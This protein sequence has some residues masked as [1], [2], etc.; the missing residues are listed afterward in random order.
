MKM[1]SRKMAGFG[2]RIEYWLI[3]Q[4]LKEGQDVYMPLVDYKGTDLLV[5]KSNGTF[6]EIQVKSSSKT[7][8]TGY[9]GLFGS[10]PHKDKKNYFYIFY[11]EKLN[12]IWIMSS[13]EF[14]KHSKQNKTGKHIGYRTIK[15]TGK[16]KD[17]SF[18]ASAKKGKKTNKREEYVHERFKKYITTDFSKFK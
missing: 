17:V 1:K 7:I 3:G 5:K 9:S 6:I 14:L 11:S 4:I 18:E 12:I 13:A 15:L 2:K 10:I 8:A 16:R